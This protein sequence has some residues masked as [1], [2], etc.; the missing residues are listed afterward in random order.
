MKNCGLPERENYRVSTC[1][2]YWTRQFRH[3]KCQA[4]PLL[5]APPWGRPA[6]GSLVCY[7]Q[8][9]PNYRCFDQ[10]LWGKGSICL[11]GPPRISGGDLQGFVCLTQSF[12][13]EFLI[14]SVDFGTFLL[15]VPGELWC[16]RWTNPIKLPV[17][18]W[19]EGFSIFYHIKSLVL[20]SL[21]IFS[22]YLQLACLPALH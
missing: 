6:L 1:R 13:P 11:C 19:G 21:N 14:S 16:W 17:K 9:S 2:R 12:L 22:R 8:R 4:A 18:I 5:F 15:E 20:S 7:Q 3:L 10:R